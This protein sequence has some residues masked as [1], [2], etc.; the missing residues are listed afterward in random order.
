MRLKEYLDELTKLHTKP[1]E[2]ALGAGVG[3]FIAILPTPGFNVLLALLVL[4]VA[5][6]ISKLALFAAL[7]IFNPLVTI[8]FHAASLWLGNQLFAAEPVVEV[9]LLEG[10]FAWTRRYLVGNLI[11]ASV[12]AL[13]VAI[14]TYTVALLVATMSTRRSR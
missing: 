1:H 5:P 10:F 14:L 13:V 7:A 12:S 4:L 2:L 9:T 8:P 6:R 3:A 11:V